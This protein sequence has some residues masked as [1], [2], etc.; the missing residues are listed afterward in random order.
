ML[1]PFQQLHTFVTIVR[2]GRMAGAADA[3]GLTPGAISQ[4]IKA[5][6]AQIGRRLLDRDR[7]GITLTRAGDALFKKLDPAILQIE[8]ALGDMPQQSTSKRITIS[9]TSSFAATWLVPR[10]HRFTALHPDVDLAV[11]TESRLVDLMSEPVDLAIRHGLGNYPGLEGHALMVPELTVVGSPDLLAHGEPVMEPMDCL[12]Y[13]LLHDVGRRDWAMWAEAVGI[14][15]P[16]P[17]NGPAYA[18]DH[19]LVRAAVAGQGLAL[20][21][22]IYAADDL[23]AGRLVQAFRGS[24]PGQFGYYLTGLPVTFRKT[25]VRAFKAWLMNEVQDPSGDTDVGRLI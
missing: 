23:A 4:R 25:A 19:L 18:D 15:M 16:I 8:Q 3:L 10:L 7:R 6:E 11:E 22:D 21:A 5:L 14:G 24:W 20:V 12:R 2:A 17:T 13:P 9:T 1:I